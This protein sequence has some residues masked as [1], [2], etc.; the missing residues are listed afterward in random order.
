M[1]FRKSLDVNARLGTAVKRNATAHY[2]RKTL[3]TR[4]LGDVESKSSDYVV[5]KS[6]DEIDP[7]KVNSEVKS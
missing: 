6:P 7:F 5:R 1:S 2:R 3:Y 4:N